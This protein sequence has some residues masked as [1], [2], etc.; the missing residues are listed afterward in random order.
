MGDARRNGQPVAQRTGGE[1]NARILAGGRVGGEGSTI[2]II[3]CQ[4]LVADFAQI[5]QT[6]VK[7][8]GGVALGKQ[9]SI[10]GIF[11]HQQNPNHQV[12]ATQRATD[13]ARVSLIVQAQDFQPKLTAELVWI[14]DFRENGLSHVVLWTAS[15]GWLISRKST[16]LFGELR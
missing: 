1:R 4:S 14:G 5:I 3:G 9:E 10:V 13:V 16:V 11:I 7:R 6:G 12:D 2:L 15:H 8:S